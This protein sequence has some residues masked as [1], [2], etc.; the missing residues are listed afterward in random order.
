MD[1]LNRYEEMYGDYGDAYEDEYRDRQRSVGFRRAR[2]ER[3]KAKAERK[4]ES[5]G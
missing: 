2:I 5:N 4:V 3:N 1:E